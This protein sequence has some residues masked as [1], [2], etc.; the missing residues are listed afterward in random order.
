MHTSCCMSVGFYRLPSPLHFRGRLSFSFW[1]Y[2]TAVE[3]KK[4]IFCLPCRDNRRQ[5]ILI[6]GRKYPGILILIWYFSRN[7]VLFVCRFAQFY[8]VFVCIPFLLPF[9]VILCL[10]IL[11]SLFCLFLCVYS[12]GFLSRPVVRRWA[13]PMPGEKSLLSRS[14][15]FIVGAEKRGGGT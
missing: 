13:R 11:H 1:L 6:S 12:S 10:A 8:A 5:K 2:H 4:I 15:R 3:R 9:P 14:A 7:A